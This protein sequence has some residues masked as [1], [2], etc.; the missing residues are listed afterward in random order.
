MQASMTLRLLR[1]GDPYHEASKFAGFLF[2]RCRSWKSFNFDGT[3]YDLG[4]E[5]KYRVERDLSTPDQHVITD[6]F[7]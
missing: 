3:P 2:C 6:E 4:R 7:H 1:V 5:R